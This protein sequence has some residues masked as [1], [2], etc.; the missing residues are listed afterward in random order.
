MVRQ[1]KRCFSE[2]FFAQMLQVSPA[3]TVYILQ[4]VNKPKSEYFEAILHVS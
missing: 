2:T 3:V 1:Q 4:R